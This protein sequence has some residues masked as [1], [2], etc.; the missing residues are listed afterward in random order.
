VSP[1]ALRPGPRPIG[2]HLALTMWTLTGAAAALPLAR[3]GM[4]PWAPELKDRAAALN[5]DLARAD[6]FGLMQAVGAEV[7]GR[8]G[9]FLT[10]VEDYRRHPYRRDVEDPPVLW[11]EGNT[12]L[13]DYGAVPRPR[14]GRPVL[15]VPSLVNRGYVLDLSERR[16]LLRHLAHQGLRPLLVDWGTPDAA[17][18]RF[19]F[20]DYISGRLSRALDRAVQ[21]AR[22]P[23]PVLGYCMG[24][25][26][27]LALG[28]LRH[29]A[30]GAL[31]L[32]A[33][34]WDF[35]AGQPESIKLLVAPNGPIPTLICQLGE[36]PIDL[37]QGF[38]VAL[39]PLLALRKFRHFAALPPDAAERE[40]FVALE[41]W[42]N[43]GVPL[44]GPVA[45]TCFTQWY[46]ANAPLKKQWRVAGT[47]IDPAKVDCP[48][49][50]VLPDRDRIV[51]PAAARALA[52][53]LPRPDVLEPAA[54]HIGMVVG[55]RAQAALWQPLAG[56]LKARWA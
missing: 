51:A 39:D 9:A 21:L 3:L 30:G 2:L 5:A 27:A 26:L 28:T 44:A 56:W 33:T 15:V 1:P 19:G 42:L 52:D 22:G 45:L 29:D 54:G 38:F 40:E 7:T 16:S 46:G 47:A 43:D 53:A 31:A 17:E 34:P 55:G 11:Q 24:G 8:T 4:V 41:D 32:L 35:H 10:A 18:K 12:R 48:T 14:G 6:V 13:L 25:N 37:L 49:L 20:D 36:M 50:V 23:V